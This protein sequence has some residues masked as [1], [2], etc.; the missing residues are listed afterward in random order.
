MTRLAMATRNLRRSLP[1]VTEF[2]SFFPAVYATSDPRLLSKYRAGYNEC[3][4]EVS[5]H[6]M[7]QDGMDPDMK[8]RILSHLA[9]FCRTTRPESQTDTHATSIGPT[10]FPYTCSSDPKIGGRR[11]YPREV[12]S[13]AVQACLSRAPNVLSVGSQYPGLPSGSL[14]LQSG[15]SLPVHF[16]PIYG[17]DLGALSGMTPVVPASPSSALQV[18]DPLWRPW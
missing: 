5:K 2:A 17:A 18:R 9:G 8:T 11:I 7:S 3:V 13:N 14:P 12:S 6:M 15:A 1:L 10:S 16:M 4:T